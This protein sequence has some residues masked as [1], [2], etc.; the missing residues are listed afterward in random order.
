M[1]N[2][3][4]REFVNFLLFDNMRILGYIN[5]GSSSCTLETPAAGKTYFSII[6]SVFG[7][8]NRSACYYYFKGVGSLSFFADV[9][10]SSGR[11]T[12]SISGQLANLDDGD[13]SNY[14]VSVLIIEVDE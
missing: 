12:Y 5:P 7:N 10:T 4:R 6:N 1:L 9:S 11:H 14:L 2:L 13:Y 3:V 8:S